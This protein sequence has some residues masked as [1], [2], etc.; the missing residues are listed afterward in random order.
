ML[1]L[2]AALLAMSAACP[3][4]VRRWGRRAFLIVALGPLAG[5]VWVAAQGPAISRG[6][7]LSE[8]HPWV[9]SIGMELAFRMGALQWLL[10]MIVL[11]VGTL[12]LA[13]C[14]WYFRK[15]SLGVPRFAGVL[16][17]F[18]AAMLGLVLADD[19]L[20]LYVFWEL[21]TVFSFLLIGHDPARRASRQA[22]IQALVVTT[23]GGLSM[24]V[25]ALILGHAGGTHR[26]SELLADPPSGV[27]VTVAVH[28][29]LVGAISKSA[30]V[31]FHFWLP[32]AM[33]APTPVSAYLHAASMVKAGVYLVALLAPVYAGVDGWRPVLLVLGIVTMLLG[34]LRALRQTDLKLL[35]AYGTVSQLGFLVMV[36]GIGTRSAL[37]AGLGLMLAHGL[38]KAT[39]F[40]V[41]GIID[42]SAGTRDLRRL[43][44]LGRKMPVV[45]GAAILAA[46]SMAGV[47]P[48]LGYVAKESILVA[49]LDV[50]KEGD[51][52]GL[53]GAVGW[54]ALAG[55]V[56]GSLL[57]AAYSARFVW[58][59]FATRDVEEQPSVAPVHAGFAA[60]PVILAGLSLA[61]GFLG[62]PV[63]E[64]LAPYLEEVPEGVHHA[65]LSLWHGL[66]LPLL[67]TLLALAG[68]ALL[69]VFRA[70]VARLQSL[71]SLDWSFERA[72][73]DGMRVLDR[74]A[75][76]VTGVVQRG[77][78]SAYLAIILAVVVVVPGSTLIGAWSDIDVEAWEH[79]A[80][81]VIGAVTVAGALMA[82]RSR[83]RLR[84][85]LLAGAT[86]YGTALLFVM[87]GA[88][89]L[90]LTQ[91]LV[92]TLTVV[93][94]VLA[95]RRMPEYFTDR[96]LSRQRYW[97]MALGLA[98][99]LVSAGF[100]LVAAGARIADPVSLMLPQE[101]VDYG[102][103]KNIVNVILVDA[104]A[105][106]TFG[107][108]TVL[109]AAATGVASLIFVNTRGTGIR[110]VHEIPYPPTVRKQPTSPGRRPWLAAPRTLPPESRSII[111]EVVT[112][113]M[114]HTIVVFSI[115]LLLVGHNEPGGGFAAGMVTGLALVVRYLVGGRYELDEAAP[116][117]AGRL[118]GGGL[119]VAA[120]AAVLP[121]AFGGSILQSAIVDLHLPALGKLHL[122][123][124]ALFDIGVY[125]VVV[126][127]VL[128]LLRALGSHIDRQVVRARRESEEELVNEPVAGETPGTEQEATR[129]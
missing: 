50:A 16:T 51:G 101:A 38:F 95:L 20:L 11:G 122:V 84:A 63:T 55:V 127:L 58:G 8:A 96:P 75:V 88:P 99:A 56:V 76:E 126:G 73:R 78:A 103:G 100:M 81:A 53:A 108:I 116:V 13:Y 105:W 67:L 35:L 60:G 23:F 80:Q 3:W 18:V 83:R 7:V 4:L 15:D 37:L 104:R 10:A 24:L 26:I 39:L 129:A 117:D 29:L 48:L 119:A 61:L 25:G 124:S 41:V 32:A 36:L 98:V 72:Y 114:F 46:A 89:D 87:Q 85:V 57:T 9:Q 118:I 69:F 1:I 107:E 82:T 42:R 6:E 65:E 47:P 30:L 66:G 43:S 90:A 112:R 106:D 34:G 31:P 115:Y 123:T 120:L 59:A 17:A 109:V 22:A 19:L 91:V 111:F 45:A 62:R 12:V 74:T 94:F 102:G 113:L 27:A 21:T 5:T 97:R 71:W 68:G 33:A 2:V 49:M 77:S 128:D 54:L 28:L 110:R 125:L 40:L 79:P 70:Q 93:V 121:L 44:G 52:T 14:T 92:E 86:G 64:M